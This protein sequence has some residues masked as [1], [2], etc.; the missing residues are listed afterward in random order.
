[1][2]KIK[3][4][5]VDWNDSE[6]PCSVDFNDIYFS[7]DSG[8][9]ESCYVFLEHN[10]LSQRFQQLAMN[11]VFVVAETGFGT[12][13]NFLCAWQLFSNVSSDKGR[14]NFISVEKFPLALDDLKKSLALWS[15]LSE[16]GEQLVSQYKA[17]HEGFQRFVFDNGRIILTLIV[18]DVA[19]KLPALNAKV[20]AWFLDGFS[21]AKNPEMWSETLFKQLARLSKRGTTFATFTSAGFVR[22]GLQ[23]IGFQVVRAKGFAD[24]REMLHGSFQ[25]IEEPHPFRKERRVIAPWF[26]RLD[27]KPFR[28][29]TAVVIGAGIAGA[30]TA[31]SLAQRGW[32]VIVLERNADIAMEGSGNAQGILYLKLSAHQTLQSRL[33]VE[34]FGYTRRLLTNLT[35]DKKLI[36][37]EDWQPCGVLQLAFD[38]KEQHRQEQLANAFSPTLLYPVTQEQ[39]SSLAGVEVS[40]KGLFFPEGG[41]VKPRNLC[42]ALLTHPNIEVRCYQTVLTIY[43][44]GKRWQALQHDELL[45]EVD[46]MILANAT[47]AKRFM[48]TNALPIKAIRG[49]TTELPAHSNAKLKTVVCSDGYISPAMNGNYCVGATFNFH[50]TDKALNTQEHLENIQTLKIISPALAN[51]LGVGQLDL[52]KLNGK[53]AYRCTAADYLPI[54]GPIANRESFLSNYK[55]L[56][57]DSKK[58]PDIPCTWHEGLFLNIAHGSRGLITAPLCGELLA[59]WLENEPF[60]IEQD[61]LEACQANRFYMRELKY[62]RSS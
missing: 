4:A 19:D 28:N 14:L 2:T 16:Y 26:D 39:A 57:K 54:V 33:L 17:I 43:H 55:V 45:A 60:A 44:T 15:S 8:L 23:D 34:G 32:H 51:D 10:Q 56:I 41:W 61:L 50:A 49:Q 11:E 21:P 9:D 59:N 6:Q 35:R 3:H 29:R 40:H 12:G 62:F 13:L 30:S 42:R 5:Q 24:K 36:E 38:K 22:R 27:N 52:D 31:A 47:E 25:K 48:M 46:I 20:D 18:G 58:I 53:V 1:M 37:H 7:K